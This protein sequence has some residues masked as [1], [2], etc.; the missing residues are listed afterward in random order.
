M[1]TTT[2]LAMDT[3]TVTENENPFARPAAVL[4]R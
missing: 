3:F 2:A 1:T 4:A